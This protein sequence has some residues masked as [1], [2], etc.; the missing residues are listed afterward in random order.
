MD[1]RQQELFYR[2]NLYEQQI[3]HLQEQLQ[4]VEQSSVEL[5][6]LSLALEELKGKKD[7]EI[8]APIG[9][10]IFIKSKILEE[11]LLVDIGG[12]NFVKKTIGETRK[13][14]DDQVGKLEQVKKEL[15]DNTENLSNEIQELISKAESEEEK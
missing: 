11:T 7:S 6:S 1:Q 10:G 2:L 9:R 12:K 13:L 3:R 15:E 8:M 14:I 5:E 4:A